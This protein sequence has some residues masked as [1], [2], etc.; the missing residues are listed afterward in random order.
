M[1]KIDVANDLREGCT[2]IPTLFNIYA[3]LVAEKWSAKVSL[4]DGIG[5]RVKYKF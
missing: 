2:L 5:V 3:C 1:E 4:I